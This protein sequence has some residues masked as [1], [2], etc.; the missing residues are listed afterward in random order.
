MDY[1]GL[2]EGF[3][4]RHGLEGMEIYDGITVLEIDG[5][6][7]GIVNDVAAGAVAVVID[8]GVPAPGVGGGICS[9]MLKANYP[10]G[11][12]DGAVLCQ[13]PE[14][15]EYAVMGWHQLSSMDVDSFS[16]ALD[17]LVEAA[18]K[19][20]GVIAGD[21]PADFSSG[22]LREGGAAFVPPDGGGFMQV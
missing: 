3:A 18:S 6:V 12:S 21:S 11:S 2:M 19:W 5:M 7:A 16:E 22:A 14:T 1:T 8:I 10:V 15:N 17:K 4:A 20:K 13:N 9:G